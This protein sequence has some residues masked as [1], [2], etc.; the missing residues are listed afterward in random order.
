MPVSELARRLGKTQPYVS[1]IINGHQGASV[2]TLRMIAEEL[3][4][5]VATLFADYKEALERE[6][7]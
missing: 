3:N 5:P 2:N 7:E 6:K 4:V 1:N